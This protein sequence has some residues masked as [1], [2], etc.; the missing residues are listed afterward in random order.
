[1]TNDALEAQ[2]TETLRQRFPHLLNGCHATVAICA[3]AALG[4][5]DLDAA[6]R[7]AQEAIFE[8]DQIVA[9]CRPN[10]GQ[11]KVG[12]KAALTATEE[13]QS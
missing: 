1:M 5:D 10:I 8:T 2:L 13:G 3:L 12:L 11:V 7:R 9:H 6:A 4:L